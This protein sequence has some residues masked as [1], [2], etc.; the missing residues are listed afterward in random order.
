MAILSHEHHHWAYT[1]IPLFGAFIWLGTL[2]AM[3]A[4]WAGQGRPVYSSE[5]G[6]IPYISDIGADIL[7]PL[8]IVGC[9]ITAVSFVA[10]LAVERGLRHTGRLIPDMRRRARVFGILAIV[11]AFIGGIGLI[12]LSIFDTKR[13]PSLH[14]LF[15]LIFM[16]G[17]ALSAIF[18]ILEFR[19]I[20]KDFQHLRALKYAYIAKG[21]IATTLIILAIAFGAALYSNRNGSQNAGAVLEWVI[22]FGFTTYLLTFWWD[23]RM[24]KG[25]HKG[26]LTR[27]KLMRERGSLST[28]GRRSWETN[29]THV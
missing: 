18:T 29:G 28:G 3:L 25:V 7:K 26:E 15:L 9:C 17:V 1:W 14:R 12:L 22:A 2:I 13:H 21:L 16:L 10:T 27:E 6:T 23:L 5:N 11:G 24:S 4:T 19:F 20:S 8:F